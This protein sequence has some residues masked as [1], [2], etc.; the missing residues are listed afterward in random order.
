MSTLS[1]ST[2]A[3]TLEALA[4][5]SVS[6]KILPLV[7]FGVSDYKNNPEKIFNQI[8]QKFSKKKCI[9]RSSATSE[10]SISQS[11]AGRFKSILNVKCVKTEIQDAIEQVIYSYKE[12]SGDNEIFVQEMLQNVDICGVAFT[13][14]LDTLSP[15][16]IVNYDTSGSTN[17][18]TGGTSSR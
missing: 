10:D 1:F 15:Y 2:K 8:N 6:A 13:S 4:K 18:V 17:S 9:V 5:F 3:K 11:N 12:T 7:R 14:D 16:Y